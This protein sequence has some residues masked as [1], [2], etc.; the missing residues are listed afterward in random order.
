VR[1]TSSPMESWKAEF[2]DITDELEDLKVRGIMG[3]V[4]ALGALTGGFDDFAEAAKNA[5]AQVIAELI[6]LQLMKLAVSLIGGAS[7]SSIGMVS[8]SGTLPPLPPIP[9][10][11][12]GGS[13][14]ILGRGGVDRNLLS[15]NGLPIARVS[16]GEKLTVQPANGNGMGVTVHAPITIQGNATRETIDQA[17]STIRRR[18]A[19][20]ARKGYG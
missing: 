16:R 8:G 9:G 12:G 6:R 19:T 7:G 11:A 17:A 2:G 15:M 14:N 13:F 3:A 18:V 5:I 10:L 20:V 4:D 1:S